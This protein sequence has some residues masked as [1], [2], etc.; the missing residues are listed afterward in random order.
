MDEVPSCYCHKAA[1][2]L[3][4]KL[5][6]ALFTSTLKEVAKRPWNTYKY[7]YNGHMGG[8]GGKVLKEVTNSP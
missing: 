8:G 1:L 5:E 3:C 4:I 2:V 6:Q 7:L